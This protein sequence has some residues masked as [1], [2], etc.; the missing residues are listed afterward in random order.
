MYEPR[1]RN[2]TQV[3][4]KIRLLCY[5]WICMDMYG[6]VLTCID[7]YEHVWTSIDMYGHLWT[8]M[9]IYGH[10]WTCMDI[11]EHVWTCMNMYWHVWTCMDMC[12]HGHKYIQVHSFLIWFLINRYLYTSLARSSPLLLRKLL[13]NFSE[14]I[15]ELLRNLKSSQRSTKTHS[16][17]S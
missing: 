12:E 7:M 11:Y 3:L 16:S 8:C 17:F 4:R 1:S 2:T 5:V 6:R 14:I 9:N 10:V 15:E 13:K